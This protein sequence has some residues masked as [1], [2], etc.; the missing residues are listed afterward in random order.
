[1]IVG[2]HLTLTQYGV[3]VETYL[4]GRAELYEDV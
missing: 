1:M 3:D 4:V 2:A